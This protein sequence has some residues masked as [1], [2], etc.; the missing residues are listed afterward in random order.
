[1]LYQYL[2]SPEY[3][4]DGIGCV[5]QVILQHQ[6]G[7]NGGYLRS[8][9]TR[10]IALWTAAFELGFD[11]VERNHC[12]ILKNLLKPTNNLFAD[13]DDGFV[14]SAFYLF[15]FAL[16]GTSISESHFFRSVSRFPNPFFLGNGLIVEA[17]ENIY[18]LM[19]IIKKY[20][21]LKRRPFVDHTMDERITVM[22]A[23]EGMSEIKRMIDKFF[24]V[25]AALFPRYRS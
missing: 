15:R 17:P 20:L 5:L 9:L 19:L 12:N 2:F 25:T 10:H 23:M 22:R 6:T 7:S 18:V 4:Q 24:L 14:L 1:L 16:M 21:T 8:A 13:D 3:S 11:A